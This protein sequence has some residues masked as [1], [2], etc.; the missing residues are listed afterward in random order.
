MTQ[1]CKNREECMMHDG[2]GWLRMMQ[3]DARWCRMLCTLIAN[4][5]VVKFLNPRNPGYILRRQTLG[6]GGRHPPYKQRLPDCFGAVFLYHPWNIYKWGAHAK[7][8]ITYFHI[9]VG[10][11]PR[12]FI[13]WHRL[14][15]LSDSWRNRENLSFAYFFSKSL[16]KLN[17]NY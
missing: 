14:I 8:W 4:L 7:N 10:G 15:W 2:A 16:S 3:D 9:L 11:P 17:Q 1:N 6:G 5:R 12:T 13:F